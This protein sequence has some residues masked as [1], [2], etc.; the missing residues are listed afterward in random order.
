VSFSIS[1]V[2]TGTIQFV[3]VVEFEFDMKRKNLS[4]G[5]V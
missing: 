5:G 1:E 2:M 4:G 3:N